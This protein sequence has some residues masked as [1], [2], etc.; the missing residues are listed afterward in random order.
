MALRGVRFGD[1]RIRSL[2]FADDVIL[3][4]PSARD[5]Q[6]SLDQFTAEH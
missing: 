2:L 4:A 3:L 5:L 6:L 1:V